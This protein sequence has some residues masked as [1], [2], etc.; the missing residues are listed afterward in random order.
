MTSVDLNALLRDLIRLHSARANERSTN[1]VL[2]CPDD[3][4]VVRADPRQL[5]Q[6][7]LNLLNNAIEAMP[8]GGEITIDATHYAGAGQGAVAV[9]ITDE[10]TGIDPS[11]TVKVFEPFFTTKTTGTGL[12]LSICREIADFHGA[13]L[14]LRRRRDRP[15]TIAEV[16]FPWTGSLHPP[17]ALQSVEDAR[18]FSGAERRASV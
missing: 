1:I 10:G 18:R 2:R 16:R 14:S 17:E 13:A 12:G 15:G 9:K 6:L 7:F 3:L 11:I 4:P 5:I 8:A